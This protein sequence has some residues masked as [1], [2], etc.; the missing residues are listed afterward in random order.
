MI[1]NPDPVIF[2]SVPDHRVGN[3]RR[4]VD[5]AKKG[6]AVVEDADAVIGQTSFTGGVCRAIAQNAICNARGIGTLDGG[7]FYVADGEYNRVLI[8]NTPP[9]AD[10]DLPDLVL[11]QPDFTTGT[12]NTGGISANTFSLPV[13][14]AYLGGKFI[15]TDYNNHRVLVWNSLP[16]TNGQAADAVIGQPSFTSATANA[17]GTATRDVSSG[18]LGGILIGDD[19]LVYTDENHRVLSRKL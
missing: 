6:S 7:R 19:I 13:D 10:G 4:E 8:W 14:V 5:P 3:S 11:G 18:P 17:G 2:R 12:A 1:S 16:T 9:T 15:V